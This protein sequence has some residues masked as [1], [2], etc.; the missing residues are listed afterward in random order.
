MDITSQPERPRESARD[1]EA[2][3]RLYVLHIGEELTRVALEEAARL[4]P[5]LDARIT[6]VAVSL[7]PFPCSLD[8]PPV[9]PRH[10]HREL[11]RLA[12]ASPMTADVRIVYARELMTGLRH[13]LP[14]AAVVLLAKRRRIWR[15]AEERLAV[16][17]RRA[18]HNVVVVPA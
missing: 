4:A 11:S 12:A 9:A 8:C 18:G 14:G 16:R 10:L 6:L 5:G 15:T 7:V 2:H 17:L 13:V 1:G 3:L